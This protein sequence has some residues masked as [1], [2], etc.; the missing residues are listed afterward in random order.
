MLAIGMF[1]L[2]IAVI[3]A[4]IVYAFVIEDTAHLDPT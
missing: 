1:C 3:S 4:A 2:G